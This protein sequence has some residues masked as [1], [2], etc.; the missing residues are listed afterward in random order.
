MALCLSHSLRLAPLFCAKN[1]PFPSTYAW[2][3]DREMLRTVFNSCHW[4]S[5]TC[6]LQG[7]S[8]NLLECI[9]GFN[10]PWFFFYVHRHYCTQNGVL[11]EIFCLVC[12]AVPCKLA[13][14][15]FECMWE[16]MRGA[17]FYW[18]RLWCPQY[19]EP[20]VTKRPTPSQKLH[21]LWPMSRISLAQQAWCKW[22]RQFARNL[23]MLIIVLALFTCNKSSVLVCR[24]CDN[25]SF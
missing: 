16:L 12:L 2:L 17:V 25:L 23:D 14:G 5:A 7:R 13:P 4:I 8:S 3:W 19:T 9:V 1:L 21:A 15:V 10:W 20:A 6:V 24:I 18:H 11:G 22:I